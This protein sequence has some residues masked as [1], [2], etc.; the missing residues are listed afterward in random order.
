MAFGICRIEHET[1][2]PAIAHI[3]ALIADAEA[4][5]DDAAPLL[6]IFG[7]N[8]TVDIG[9][10]REC[11]RCI[12]RAVC[13]D[14]RAA[15]ND[16]EVFVGL[17][18]ERRASFDRQRRSV[19]AFCDTGSLQFSVV[20]VR[21]TDKSPGVMKRSNGTVSSPKLSLYS[22]LLIRASTTP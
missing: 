1:S 11:D 6:N 13:Q 14:T 21:L 4:V 16:D 9:D 15:I 12:G 5:D 22:R 10:R 17:E 2:F 8:R 3:A 19:A 20:G 18:R 7:T